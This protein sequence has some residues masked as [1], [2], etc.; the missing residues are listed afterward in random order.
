MR[1]F[2][3]QGYFFWS[4]KRLKKKKAI[5]YFENVRKSHQYLTFKLGQFV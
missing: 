5:K 3:T 2:P 4:Q 1:S